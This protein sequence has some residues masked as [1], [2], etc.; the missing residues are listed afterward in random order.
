M[1]MEL[2]YT[3][4]GDYL[5][6]NLAMPEEVTPIGKYGML[7]KSYLQ[8]EQMGMYASLMLSGKLHAH[9]TEIEQTLRQQLEV[10]MNQLL[11]T[12]PAPDKASDPM[13]WMAHMNSL[14]QQAEELLL[15]EL[16]Y[17]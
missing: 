2:T 5:L 14:K 8:T 1:S 3:R 11:L 10:T 7:R 4:Q 16:I 17:S 12:Q 15:P 9:L 6:P 13:A